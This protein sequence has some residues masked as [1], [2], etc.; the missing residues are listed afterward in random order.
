MWASR[1]N[2]INGYQMK[3]WQSLHGQIIFCSKPP[4]FPN[5]IVLPQMNW[6]V[7]TLS[8]E[9]ISF[10]RSVSTTFSLDLLH[11]NCHHFLPLANFS[12]LF[13]ICHSP[14]IYDVCKDHHIYLYKNDIC[15]TNTSSHPIQLMLPSLC[16]SIQ[17]YF[18]SN[19]LLR[20]E[21]YFC[22]SS[23]HLHWT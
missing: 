16:A 21:N 3:I 13:S 23:H 9:Q 11:R 8:S 20:R 5:S 10:S 6:K 4:S 18:S 17:E 22:E 19:C 1:S 15:T 7:S 14:L 12:Y 2:A